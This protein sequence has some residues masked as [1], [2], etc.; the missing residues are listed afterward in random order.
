MEEHQHG[1]QPKRIRT[2]PS[3]A[4]PGFALLPYN[5]K[6]AFIKAD[7]TNAV[8]ENI[9]SKIRQTGCR[10][11]L[12]APGDV[13]VLAQKLSCAYV[14]YRD[15]AL[16]L[17]SEKWGEPELLIEVANQKV[18]MMIGRSSYTILKSDNTDIATYARRAA[19]LCIYLSLPDSIGRDY[20]DIV[21]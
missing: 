7:E 5:I 19:E 17:I 10:V 13:A 14:P 3:G 11:A 16:T 2:T 12:S 9:A 15:D 20:G 6:T 18:N 4:K 21:I 1:V 8:L